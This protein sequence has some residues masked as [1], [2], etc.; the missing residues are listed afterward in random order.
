MSAKKPTAAKRAHRKRKPT[1]ADRARKWR[2]RT[3]PV[4]PVMREGMREALDRRYPDPF[5]LDQRQQRSMWTPTAEEKE[6]LEVVFD[7]AR[8]SPLGDRKQPQ[9]IQPVHVNRRVEE[10]GVPFELRLQ[11]EHR[12][13]AAN[14]ERD[15]MLDTHVGYG[16]HQNAELEDEFAHAAERHQGFRDALA[17]ISL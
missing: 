3:V 12:V 9:H 11:L 5:W 2:V 6:R 7:P 4:T 15:E 17:G 14:R 16:A 10:K 13:A 8:P 1:A